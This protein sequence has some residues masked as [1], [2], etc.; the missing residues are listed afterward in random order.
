ML[1]RFQIEFKELFFFRISL[2]KYLTVV[3][4]GFLS[5]FD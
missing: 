2:P 1:N 4:Q 3:F 5:K